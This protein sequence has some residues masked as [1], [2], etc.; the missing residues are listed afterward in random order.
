MKQIYNYFPS[1]FNEKT[2]VMQL[3]FILGY[4]NHWQ[5]YHLAICAFN[6]QWVQAG[7]ES[8]QPASAGTHMTAHPPVRTSTG[9]EVRYLEFVRHMPYT[10]YVLTYGVRS[11]VEGFTMLF[12]F[13]DLTHLL[14]L[15]NLEFLIAFVFFRKIH[16]CP[17]AGGEDYYK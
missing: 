12:P 5:E 1:V 7:N 11:C 14:S 6:I 13:V 17:S 15:L 8:P 9:K 3:H 16:I 10:P 2:D 4:L